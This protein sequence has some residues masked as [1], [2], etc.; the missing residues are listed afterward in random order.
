M[1]ELSSTFCPVCARQLAKV[2]GSRES[3]QA[4]GGAE[5]GADAGGGVPLTGPQAALY[6][7]ET[8]L[9]H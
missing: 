9:V 1:K 5:A 8:P 2:F 6:C 7:P 3:G 4:D